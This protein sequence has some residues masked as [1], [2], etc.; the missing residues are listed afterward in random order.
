M[1]D[2]YGSRELSRSSFSQS[3]GD[4]LLSMDLWKLNDNQQR[5]NL[6]SIHLGESLSLLAVLNNESAEVISN[7]AIQIELQTGT[8]RSTLFKSDG[9]ITVNQ[10]ESYES[11]IKMEVKELGVHVI[12]CQV[13]FKPESANPT[14]SFRKFFKFTSISPFQLKTK[15]NEDLPGRIFVQAQLMNCSAAM[16]QFLVE[17]LR[18]I[19]SSGFSVHKPFPDLNSSLSK[20]SI[21]EDSSVVE[22]EES[23]MYKNEV[24]L[25]PR[26]AHFFVFE[27][28]PLNDSEPSESLGCLDIRWKSQSGEFGHLQTGS[29]LR[30]QIL[31]ESHVIECRLIGKSLQ[32]CTISELELIVAN[33]SSRQIETIEFG[34]DPDVWALSSVFTPCGND[35]ILIPFLK[36]G[37][38]ALRKLSVIPVQSGIM[39]CKDF[40]LKY[41]D[42]GVQHQVP[43][44]YTFFIEYKKT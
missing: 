32:L 5:H 20:L 3:Q 36:S 24:I 38:T 8:Q 9:P 25:N 6:G 17:E 19:A 30:K 41:V 40:R 26:Q 1:H 35:K 11:I 2:Q 23:V 43:K 31:S 21:N 16:P 29:I 7:V 18:F 39:S 44:E 15:V 42:N 14:K 33:K 28:R 27:L 13:T 34:F 22:L 10:R 12:S 4:G 37:E